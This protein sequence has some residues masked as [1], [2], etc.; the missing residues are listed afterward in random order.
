MR[1]K[2]R[3]IPWCSR[4]YPCGSLTEKE[5]SFSVTAS[6]RSSLMRLHH[7]KSNLSMPGPSAAS[8]STSISACLPQATSCQ[9]SR[10]NRTVCPSL[11]RGRTGSLSST[12]L[13][14]SCFSRGW[15]Y[16]FEE[17]LL[18]DTAGPILVERINHCTYC[19][20]GIS[21]RSSWS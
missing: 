3:P 1:T 10:V 17:L 8:N 15:C 13:Q 18:A 11:S 9:P 14:S 21:K 7:P 19:V 5:R 6:S 16:T 12:Q 4:L 2:H 20:V